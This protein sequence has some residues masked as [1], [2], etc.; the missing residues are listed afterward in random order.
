MLFT[1]EQAVKAILFDLDGVFYEGDEPVSGAASVIRWVRQRNIPYLFLTNTTSRDRAAL[2][3]KLAGFGIDTNPEHILT[4]PVAAAAW[5]KRHVQGNVALFV[6]DAIEHEFS[7]LKSVSG[8]AEND[9][10]AI[11]LGD[12]GE[13]WDYAKLNHAFRLLMRTPQPRLIALGM[14]RYWKAADGLRLD[15][16]PFVVALQH[17]TG[18]EPTVLGKPSADFYAMALAMLKV[19]AADTIIVGDDIRSDIDGAQQCGIR[20]V[21]VRTGKFH[22]LDLQT[23]INPYA[24]LDS[25]TDLPEWWEQKN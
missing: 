4:P 1:K 6:P 17:A 23:D 22:E 21:L 14:T 20:G 16:A 8:D 15:V 18:A 5:L 9:I 19:D 11:V 13:R 12:L 25:V 24:I 3:G 2:A 7:A 10:G